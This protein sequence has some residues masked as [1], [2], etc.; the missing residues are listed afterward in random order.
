MAKLSEK[1]K[2]IGDQVLTTSEVANLVGLSEHY[3]R[4]AVKENA[5]QTLRRE[6]V[7]LFW[8][9]DVLRW[10]DYVRTQVT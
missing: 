10:R 7:V 4:R 3:V 5:L 9:D 6:P 8:R 1:R 2:A